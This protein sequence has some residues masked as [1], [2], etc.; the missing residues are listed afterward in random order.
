VKEIFDAAGAALVSG[1]PEQRN[2]YASIV[3]TLNEAFKGCGQA[4]ASCS[5][6]GGIANVFDSAETISERPALQV[7][8]YPNP[9]TDH[10]YFH[11]VSPVSGEAVFEIY[12]FTG[13]RLK[14]I[15]KPNVIANQDIL[16]KYMVP[17]VHHNQI[18]Y[19]ITVGKYTSR[20]ILIS[21][22][23]QQ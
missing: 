16:I 22:Q 9:F 19:R 18:V 23:R 10:V 21:P 7:R 3:S 5:G 8:T 17:K 6:G 13:R 2:K 11:F 20:G 15:N 14:Q 4:V 1:T 12:D